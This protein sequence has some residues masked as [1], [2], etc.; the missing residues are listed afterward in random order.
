MKADHLTL[1]MFYELKGEPDRAADELEAYLRKTP[2][3]ANAGQVREHLKI[4]R[5]GTN[6]K[7]PSTP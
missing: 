5:S 4:L 6:G 7:K 2:S 1:A 3:A